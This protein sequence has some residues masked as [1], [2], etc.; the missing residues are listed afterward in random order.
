M[1]TSADSRDGN[2][3]LLQDGLPRFDLVEPGHVVP[4]IRT[5]LAELEQDFAAI[6]SNAS[7]SWDA[8]VV[9]LERL[10]DRLSLAWGTVGH[11]MGVRNSEPLREAYEA[12]QPEV[13][14]FSLRVGQSRP[15][16]RALKELREGPG[17]A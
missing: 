2:P 6:E 12:I 7:P 3:L 4:G 8:V 14:T 5:L 13:V 16:Y 11:L 1:D 15:V 10:N 17:W 9:P